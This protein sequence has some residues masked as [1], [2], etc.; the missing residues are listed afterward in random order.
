LGA[1]PVYILDEAKNAQCAREMMESNNWIVPTFNGVLRTDKPPLHYF[2]MIAAYKVFGTTEFAARFFSVIMGL[3]TVLFT[4]LY[5]KRLYN[6]FTAFCSAL[7]LVT[8][9]HFLFEFRL[10][11][12]DPYLICFITLGLFSA[13][14]WLQENNVKQLYIAAAA[15]GFAVLAKGPVALALPG[16]CLVIWIII[17]KKWKTVFTWHL[18]P[19]ALLL[20]MITVP[21]YYAVDKATDGAWTKGFFIDNNLNRFSDPQEGHG[22][23]FL[24]TLLFVLVGLLPF[25][26]F[27][28]EIIKQRKNIFSHPI[29]KFGA[30]VTITFVVFFSLSSTKLPNYPMPCYPFAAVVLGTFIAKLLNREIVSKKYPWYILLVFTIVLP[31]GAY[32]AIKA[33]PEATTLANSLPLFLLVAPMIMLVVT[34]KYKYEWFQKIE[35]IVLSFT[36]LNIAGLA[37][38]YPELY[39]QNPVAKTMDIVKAAPNIYAYDIFNPGYRFYLDKNIPQ[40]HDKATMQ[41][42]L[43]STGNAIIITRQIISIH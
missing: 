28:G 16:L 31:I 3:F 29:T 14:T 26:S 21:W 38:A 39:K 20:C 13:F 15:L 8:S 18:I 42:W 5:T 17:S 22:G 40:A 10:S 6:I 1:T 7:V 33:E 19:V 43:D 2:F 11:V 4:F 24:V 34:L 25:I 35:I 23:F 27:I 36:S 12:P 32:F 37:Y 30:V 41:H 9:T